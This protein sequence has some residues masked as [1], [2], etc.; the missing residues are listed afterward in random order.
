MLAQG[1]VA[2]DPRGVPSGVMGH[3]VWDLVFGVL[4][5][6]YDVLARVVGARLVL[7]VDLV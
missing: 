7:W 4:V 6:W 2:M 5:L 1:D 3:D